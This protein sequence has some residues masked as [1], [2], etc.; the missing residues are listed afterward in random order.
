MIEL[1]SLLENEVWI[2]CYKKKISVR[3]MTTFHIQNT[4]KCW[5]G[6]GKTVIPLNYLVKTKNDKIFRSY[7]N[8]ITNFVGL[9]IVENPTV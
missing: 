2:T 9:S 1:N 6:E 7:S 8:Q 3:E 5:K 4:I